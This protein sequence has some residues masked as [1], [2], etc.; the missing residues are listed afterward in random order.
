MDRAVRKWMQAY[1]EQ[2]K[3]KKRQAIK[4]IEMGDIW[5]SIGSKEE[6]MGLDC[7]GAKKRKYI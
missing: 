6:V 5:H 1:H 2:N 3:A 4:I 7:T